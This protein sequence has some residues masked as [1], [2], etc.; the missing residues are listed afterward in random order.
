[1]APRFDATKMQQVNRR[2]PL[3]EI[4]RDNPTGSSQGSTLKKT[5][6]TA[7]DSEATVSQCDTL[8]QELHKQLAQV[9]YNLVKRFE[10]ENIT[11][12]FDDFFTMAIFI[13]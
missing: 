10:I 5:T 8:L 9:K 7:S 4:N 1:M 12:S 13:F 2:G 11:L 6:S 3:Q